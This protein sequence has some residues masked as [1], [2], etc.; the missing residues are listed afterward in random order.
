MNLATSIAADLHKM[1]HAE[2]GCQRLTDQKDQQTKTLK[3]LRKEHKQVKPKSWAKA[4]GKITT[5][6]G[7]TFLKYIFEE[8]KSRL[9]RWANKILK[10]IPNTWGHYYVM[11]K[12]LLCLIFLHM[13]KQ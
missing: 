10:R 5:Q 4:E 1:Q 7:K 11:M 3:K 2:K 8:R 12:V 6:A 13:K 9:L